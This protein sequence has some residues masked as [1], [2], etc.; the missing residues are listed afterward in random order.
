MDPNKIVVLT[1][2][3][4][5]AES[6]LKTFRDH[7]GLWNNYSIEDV[8]TPQGWAKDP[9]LV[10]KFYNERRLQA[11][12][13]EPN[14]A[15][16]ALAALEKKYDVTIIT[17]NV[18]DLH[19]R[20]GSTNVIHVHGELAKAR[21]TADPNLI[22]DIGSNPIYLG[23]T[24][25]A[26]FQLRPNIVWFGEAVPALY[27]CEEIVPTA[28]KVLVVGT[29]LAVYPV[30]GLVEY[31]HADAEKV[32]VAFDVDHL[33]NAYEYLKKSATEALPELLKRWM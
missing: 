19:E 1:G 24:C 18:D 12:Q 27:E 8:A 21:S 20:A 32:L 17:Q 26:G 6:G 5:S 13:A 30:A 33:P 28:G 3:G 29:S 11:A 22:Y 14:A 10:L 16:L 31:A 7:D 4:I 25:D 9:E 23:D 2:A 15:H